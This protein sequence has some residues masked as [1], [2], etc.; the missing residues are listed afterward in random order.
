MKTIYHMAAD[1]VD[2]DADYSALVITLRM[3]FVTQMVKNIVLP[4]DGDIVKT[5]TPVIDFLKSDKGVQLDKTL[6]GFY[7]DFLV[8]MDNLKSELCPRWEDIEALFNLCKFTESKLL[9]SAQVVSESEAKKSA[10]SS[11]VE[12]RPI[13]TQL[14]S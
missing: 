4:S 6:S 11:S 5:M 1:L 8:L 7:D 3:Y 2:S 9:V 13:V 14:D 10:C 12:H